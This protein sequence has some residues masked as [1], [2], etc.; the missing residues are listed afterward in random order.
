MEQ[1]KPRSQ[2]CSG[3]FAFESILFGQGFFTPISYIIYMFCSSETNKRLTTCFPGSNVLRRL[4]SASEPLAL[5]LRVG[6]SFL[7]LRGRGAERHKSRSAPKRG[8]ARRRASERGDTHVNAPPIF[9][10]TVPDISAGVKQPIPACTAL[11]SPLSTL[12]FPHHTSPIT[13]FLP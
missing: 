2:Y 13:Y 5:Y 11:H 7:A 12:L 9:T 6:T 1:K 4:R 3:S 10:H 8:A